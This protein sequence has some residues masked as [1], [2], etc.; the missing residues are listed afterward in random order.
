[1]APSKTIHPDVITRFCG[2][3]P[4]PAPLSV[5]VL[6]DSAGFIGGY[7]YTR[8]IRD[9][10]IYYLDAEGQPYAMFHIYGPAEEKAKN[11]PLI[12]TLREAYPI[13]EPLPC[14]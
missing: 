4:G 1:M 6:K 3:A 14:P 7:T 5:K 9:S 2:I 8:L 10:P 12:D 13:E 11:T